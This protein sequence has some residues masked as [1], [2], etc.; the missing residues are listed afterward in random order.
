MAKL[1][2]WKQDPQKVET[3]IKRGLKTQQAISEIARRASV[4]VM[5][6]WR[7]NAKYGIRPFEQ[8][9][10]IGATDG[11]KKRHSNRAKPCIFSEEQ[12]TQLLK[13]HSGAITAVAKQS[14]KK[15]WNI[16]KKFGSMTDFLNEVNQYIFRQ[17]DYYDPSVKGR[18]GKTAE[19]I[20]WMVNGA[21]LFCLR[22]NSKKSAKYTDEPF[23]KELMSGA[24]L[25]QALF[26]MPAT[27]KRLLK[28]IGFDL[29]TVARLGF[30]GIKS[31]L[32]SK[33]CAGLSE[34]EKTVIKG[35]LDGKKLE[36]IG[37]G[38]GMTRQNASLI[39]IRAVKKIRKNL[40]RLQTAKT[41]AF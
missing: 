26:T 29:K 28:N 20:T 4:N 30:E 33:A 17:L 40:A 37:K 36:I 35:S 8:V 2:R 14:W 38:L 23:R 5:K 12:K 13:Q 32:L 7:R 19:P 3:F 21:K 39:R 34:R 9:R 6:V 15:S 18:D 25:Q 27:G 10:R 22:A 24:E 16:K 1:G 41:Q 31:Q 11:Q